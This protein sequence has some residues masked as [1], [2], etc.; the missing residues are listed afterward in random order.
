MASSLRI[1]TACAHPAVREMCVVTEP[2]A[3]GRKRRQHAVV[4]SEPRDRRT[5][6]LTP[7]FVAYALRGALDGGTRGST[8]LQD[9]AW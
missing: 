8:E 6:L 5:A 2:K 9:E 3:A 4:V 1:S 7:V